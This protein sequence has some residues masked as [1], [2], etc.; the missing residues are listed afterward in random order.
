MSKVKW[1]GTKLLKTIAENEEATT[2]LYRAIASEARIGEKFFELLAEDEERHEKIYRALLKNHEEAMDLDLDVEDAEY[3]D[4]LV[5]SNVVFTD[6]L[7]EKAKKIYTKSQ[8]FDIAERAERDA[9]LFV[10]ELQR[11]YPDLAKE[12]MAII[13]KEEQN[14]LKK[15]LQRRRE[16]QSMFGRGM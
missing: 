16:S 8:I 10:S 6:E 9:V 13:L 2:K 11:L 15:V 4:L 3:V 5:E 12:E 7:I 14:H 1:N